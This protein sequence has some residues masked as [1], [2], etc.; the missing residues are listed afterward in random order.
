MGGRKWWAEEEG[1]AGSPPAQE[2]LRALM[3]VPLGSGPVAGLLGAVE[4]SGA[5]ASGVCLSTQAPTPPLAEL[6]QARALC[7]PRAARAGVL[8][9]RPGFSPVGASGF[10][11]TLV[12]GGVWGA[13]DCPMLDLEWWSPLPEEKL[14]VGVE[15]VDPA[16]RAERGQPGRVAQLQGKCGHSHQG[17]KCAGPSGPVTRQLC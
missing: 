2:A 1:K 17:P 12:P 14:D 6:P 4:R 10:T 7:R 5:K 16:G 13:V 15:G 3:R 11:S 8:T 9:Q